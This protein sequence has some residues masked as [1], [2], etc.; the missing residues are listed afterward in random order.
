FRPTV[1]RMRSVTIFICGLSLL[2]FAGRTFPLSNP[3]SSVTVPQILEM[4]KAGVSPETIVQKMRDSGTVNRLQASQLAQLKEQ[5]VPDAVVNNM[6]QPYLN[7]ARADQRREEFDDWAMFDAG[8]LNGGPW[9]YVGVTFLLE[10]GT[11]NATCFC[12]IYRVV[13]GLRLPG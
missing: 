12:H 3:R 13:C 11:V 1:A 6:Q 8:S 4:S 2:G 7:A 5:G 9:W 10:L